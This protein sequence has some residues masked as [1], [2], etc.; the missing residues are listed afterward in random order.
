MSNNPK[1][2]KKIS[3]RINS[4]FENIKA[5]LFILYFVTFEYFFINKS[6]NKALIEVKELCK[7]LNKI[8]TTKNTINKIYQI[9]RNKIR[10]GMHK[11]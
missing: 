1:Y 8:C 10:L 3:L 2:D 4:V 5:L 7:Q 6:I 9:L 11:K